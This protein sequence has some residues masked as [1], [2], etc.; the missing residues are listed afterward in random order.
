PKLAKLWAQRRVLFFA[1]TNWITKADPAVRRSQRFDAVLFVAPPSLSRKRAVLKDLLNK[2]D[3]AKVSET[4]VVEALSDQTNPLGWL[5]LLRH[6]H[7]VD[8]QQLLKKGGGN[9]RAT[10]EELR[11]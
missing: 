10:F 5:A 9:E 11:Q 6:E 2:S 4:T 1:N 7:I 8:L 3:Y